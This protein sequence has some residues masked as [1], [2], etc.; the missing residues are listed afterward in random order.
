M[1]PYPGSFQRGKR[2][3]SLLWSSWNS[4]KV[5][6]TNWG[7]FWPSLRILTTYVCTER[8]GRQ[9]A[10]Q[11]GVSIFTVYIHR[12]DGTQRS[13]TNMTPRSSHSA[14]RGCISSGRRRWRRGE[15]G[16]PV[17]ECKSWGRKT[18][19][20][21][22][23]RANRRIVAGQGCGWRSWTWWPHCPDWTLSAWRGL[24]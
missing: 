4:S 12:C 23:W 8:T 24:T 20:A 11:S 22:R 2:M 17:S 16:P 3:V 10:M 21:R 18:G 1:I 15:C 9:T 14:C 7:S 6:K 19:W 13:Q 5:R